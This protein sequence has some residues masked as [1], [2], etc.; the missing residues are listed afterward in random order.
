MQEQAQAARV[1]IPFGET[2]TF[3]H[4]SA[5]E[6]EYSIDS[7]GLCTRRPDD[8]Y[9]MAEQVGNVPAVYMLGEIHPD[10]LTNDR[11]SVWEITLDH[12][13]TDLFHDTMNGATPSYYTTQDVPRGKMK[14]ISE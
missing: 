4:I 12:T 7:Q 6:D 9:S 1:V 8:G 13:D 5:Y 2:R 3:Y 14:L 10:T 11:F